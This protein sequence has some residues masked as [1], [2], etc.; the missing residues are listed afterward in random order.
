MAAAALLQ[1]ELDKSKITPKDGL[2]GNRMLEEDDYLKDPDTFETS[3]TDDGQNTMTRMRRSD[4]SD[5]NAF[6]YAKQQAK[7]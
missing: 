5:T 6:E 1:D 2:V 7:R 4:L 3:F